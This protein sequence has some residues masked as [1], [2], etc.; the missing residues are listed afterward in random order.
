MTLLATQSPVRSSRLHACDVVRF[1][2]GALLLF[3]AGMKGYELATAPVAEVN[4]LTTR[5]F[6]VAAVEFELC[7]GLCLL[8]GLLPRLTWWVSLLCFAGFAAI[9]AYKAWLGEADCGCFGRAHLDPRITLALDLA[10]IVALLLGRPGQSEA[11]A[12]TNGFRRVL[13]VAVGM[14]AIGIPGGWLMASA[15]PASL[16]DDGL[17]TAGN[18]VVLEP[19][20]WIG[21]PCRL[22]EHIDIGRQLKTGNWLVVL[23]SHSCSHCA[24]TMPK[25]AS[26]ARKLELRDG[27]PRMALVQIPPADANSALLA[28]MPGSVLAG[29]LEASREWFAETPVEM[30]LENGMVLRAVSKG[31]G[32]SGW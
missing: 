23:Y 26:I 9:T 14:L 6:L 18:F 24:Q 2:V 3:A 28:E 29:R 16:T 32:L 17:I 19:E 13:I 31:E 20:K 8:A 1:L 30:E 7:L 15:K 5:W 22:L 12:P 21:K 4:L 27:G 25:Y 10:V 11:P